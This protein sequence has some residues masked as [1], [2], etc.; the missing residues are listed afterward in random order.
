MHIEVD[1]ILFDIDGTLVDSTPAV[2]RAWRTWAGRHGLDAD[3]ILSISHGRRAMDTVAMFV[4]PAQVAQAT[5]E[6][7][8]L[9]LGDFDGVVALPAAQ[10]LL[11][12]LPAHRWAAVTSG[13]SELMRK[14]LAVAGLAVPQVFVT[15][16][17]VVAG[18]PDPEGYQKAAAAL[19]VDVTR[20]LVV[21]DAPAGIG[22]G[23]AAGAT[24]LAVCTS[25]EREELDAELIVPDLTAVGITVGQRSL[26]VTIYS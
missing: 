14:R 6:L 2:E 9:E 19:G 3:E 23:Q 16:E 7:S 17:D 24:V 15:A 4:P 12:S 21:E 8:A 11:E 20:C 5:S 25:H 26:G 10:A 18:K 22:A 13:P 1:A